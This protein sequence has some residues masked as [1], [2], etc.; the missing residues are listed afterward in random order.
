MLDKLN[1]FVEPRSSFGSDL[2]SEEF[3][4]LQKIVNVRRPY[5]LSDF[6]RKYFIMSFD[7]NE[8]S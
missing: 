6:K 8:R 4:V 7:D 1:A 2:S 5:R 3:E